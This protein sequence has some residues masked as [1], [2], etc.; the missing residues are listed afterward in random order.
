MSI[1]APV[2]IVGGGW[3]GLSTAI[4]L[5]HHKI[6]VTLIDSNQQLGGRGRTITINNMDI[7]NGQH[8]LIGA[9]SE[10]LRLLK[11]MGQQESDLFDRQPTLLHSRTHKLPGFRLAL[12]RI[13]APLNFLLGLLSA[14]GF[15]IKEKM[16]I[17]QLCLMLNRCDFSIDRDQNLSAWLEKNGQTKKITQQFWR[18]LCLAMLNTPI[19]IASSKVFL[20]VLKDS[21]TLK[22]DYSDFLFAKHNIG[23]LFP[24]PAEHYLEKN[25]TTLITGERVKAIKQT[26]ETTFIVQT[27]DRSIKTQHIVLAMPP[28]QCLRLIENIS[29]LAPLHKQLE[30]FKTSPITTIYLHYPKHVSLGQDM[31]GISGGQLEWLVDRSTSKQAG[32]IAG[33]ISGPG[34]HMRLSKETLAKKAIVEIATLFPHWPE[35]LQVSVVREKRATFLCEAGVNQYRPKNKTA[36]PNLWLAG[37]HTDTGYP[38]TLEGAVRSGVACSQEILQNIKRKTLY[39]TIY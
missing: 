25:G 15:S 23:L 34:S 12:P 39:K 5:S 20:R 30:C 8:L 24:Q 38:S 1:L 37:D 31:L 22:R 26:T 36:I 35:P 29:A 4:E 6:A 16:A 9:Y 33:I 28:K 27:N 32:I 14:K 10:T 17:L 21:F 19:D 18:P 7:D 11:L 13:A 3:A 2:V